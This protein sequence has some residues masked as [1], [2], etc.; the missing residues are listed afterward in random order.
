M[1]FGRLE[2]AGE[3]H[4]D[5]H[6]LEALHDPE[7]I[8]P[9]CS[10]V[11]VYF[12]L[13]K[14]WEF[15]QKVSLLSHPSKFI[16][17]LCWCICESRL[18]PQTERTGA[19]ALCGFWICS[20]RGATWS[21]RRGLAHKLQDFQNSNPK[22]KSAFFFMSFLKNWAVSFRCSV[23]SVFTNTLTFIG[24]T[25]FFCM[26]VV[27]SA[28]FQFIPATVTSL[29]FCALVVTITMFCTLVATKI[30]FTL[31]LQNCSCC[32]FFV[33]LIPLRLIFS[34]FCCY[35]DLFL[36]FCCSNVKF[37]ILSLLQSLLFYTFVAVKIYFLH[38]CW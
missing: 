3:P 12:A 16:S 31:F 7:E 1:F 38:F 4:R 2:K 17:Y 26:F 19:W 13:L 32:N 30:F 9:P 22:N 21:F 28:F 11:H 5:K 18:H 36:Y 15:S 33:L 6:T 37:F 24:A 27:T 35:N 23:Y 14:R 20:P 10:H 25:S 29:F 8:L 34:H